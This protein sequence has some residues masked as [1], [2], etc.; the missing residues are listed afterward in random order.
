MGQKELL[1]YIRESLRAGVPK[2]Q[3]HSVLLEQGWQAEEINQ[4]F[5]QAQERIKQGVLA[6]PKPPQ[7][8]LNWSLEL[9]EITASRILL[10]L[11]GLIVILAGIIY[12]GI[13]W[14]QWRPT[15]RILAIFLPMLICYGAGVPMW[16]A[17]KNRWQA[18]AFVVTGALL[19]PLFLLV[20]FTQLVIM[21]ETPELMALV[22]SVMSFGLYLA[23]S[24]IFPYPAWS[25]LYQVAALFAY[26]YFLEPFGLEGRRGEDLR[27]WLFLIP[28]TL[29]LLLSHVHE[30]RQDSSA[31]QH[32]CLLGTAVLIYSIGGLLIPYDENYYAWA[33]PF[34]G[35]AYFTLGVF[36]ETRPYQKYYYVPYR[37]GAAVIVAAL[38][39]LSATG[40]LFRV[41]IPDADRKL[42][43]DLN[44][45]SF[46]IVGAIWLFIAWL[47]GKLRGF[48]LNEACKFKGLFEFVGVLA[49]LGGLYLLGKEGKRIGY[50]TL[51]LVTSLGFIF[52]SILWRSRSFLY[53]GTLFLVV[54]VFSI[55]SEY[56][57]NKVGW[58]MTLFAAGLVSMGIG[59]SIGRLRARY[60]P[61]PSSQT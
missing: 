2:E 44:S 49:V 5:N 50:E 53:V 14:Q 29:Y 55:G 21:P 10:Y 31:A 1:D 22:V 32:A 46:I 42:A 17:N 9:N 11:G 57:Q 59:I 24:F 15:A 41:F 3:I 54:Y 43:R 40:E 6:P 33:F 36:Y 8:R 7:K 28:G 12:V 38:L 18:L 20:F 27:A 34:I 35:A 4:A 47:I 61:S 52:S 39:K 48:R 16:F 23:S 13:S 58:P 37:L 25:F 19:F 60:F 51:L 26:F 45:W 56:F 30:K